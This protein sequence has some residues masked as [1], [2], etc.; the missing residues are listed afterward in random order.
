[1]MADVSLTVNKHM[2]NK[3]SIN[4]VNN[5]LVAGGAGPAVMNYQPGL[6][7]DVGIAQIDE[8]Y[9]YENWRANRYRIH[10]SLVT[11]CEATNAHNMN[12]VKLSPTVIVQVYE[13]LS[14]AL[15]AAA[16]GTSPENETLRRA[17][18]TPPPLISSTIELGSQMLRVHSRVRRL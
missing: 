17:A 10:V 8:I 5:M 16:L 7:N 4:L 14:P 13:H 2:K 3:V 15:V 9:E 12:V 1:M 18:A 6:V 11:N